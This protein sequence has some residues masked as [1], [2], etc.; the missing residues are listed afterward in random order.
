[1]HFPRRG[2]AGCLSLLAG[3]LG[4]LLPIRSVAA[5]T[6]T[7]TLVGP[8]RFNYASSTYTKSFPCPS[9]QGSFT[10]NVVDGDGQGHD[11]ISSA[12]ISINGTRVIKSSDFNSNTTQINKAVTNL[13]FG[14]NTLTVQINTSSPS[15]YLV[16]TINGVYTLDVKINSPIGG[17][18]F[19]T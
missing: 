3:I 2:L 16:I 18:H 17:A 19:N 14:N 8:E 15:S 13:V 5:S 6:I 1:M 9:A 4:L 10:I 7:Q 11:T 12:N